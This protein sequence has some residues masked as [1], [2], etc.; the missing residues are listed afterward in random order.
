MQLPIDVVGTWVS[1][2]AGDGALFNQSAGMSTTFITNGDKL[3]Q[4]AP[5]TIT[6]SVIGGYALPPFKTS[7]RS[8]VKLCPAIAQFQGGAALKAVGISPAG[9][10]STTLTSP[11]SGVGPRFSTNKVI[12]ETAPT[13]KLLRVSVMIGPA[14]DP[15]RRMVTFGEI[16]PRWL[17]K[18]KSGIPSPLKSP[19]A[20]LY[21][22]PPSENGLQ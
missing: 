12:A 21:E 4:A 6:L 9:K 5:V 19:I 11:E 7:D 18:T 20:K 15:P 17:A 14:A 10:T 13:S 16:E 22:S 2:Y 1:V 3:W 8:Q